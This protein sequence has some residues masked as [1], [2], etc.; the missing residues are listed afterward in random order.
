MFSP[1]R[2][3]RVEKPL[4]RRL[5]LPKKEEARDLDD[6]IFDEEPQIRHSEK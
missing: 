5:P 6:Y 4:P 1:R 3:T 2:I